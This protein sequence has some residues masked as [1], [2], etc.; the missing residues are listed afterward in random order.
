MELSTSS[1]SLLDASLPIYQAA[2][3]GLDSGLIPDA[4][5]QGQY[6]I[7]N[8]VEGD[9]LY[10]LSGHYYEDPTYWV[11]IREADCTTF[12]GDEAR[13]I[14]VGTPVYLPVP[15]SSPGSDSLAPTGV[16]TAPSFSIDQFPLTGQWLPYVIQYG[17]RL[18]NIAMDLLGDP[19][20]WTEIRKDDGTVFAPGEER[21]LKPGMTVLIP[22]SSDPLGNKLTVTVVDN[23]LSPENS[24][25]SIE[26]IDL[27][28]E[29]LIN[30]QTDVPIFGIS[31]VFEGTRFFWDTGIA[32]ITDDSLNI[33]VTFDSDPNAPLILDT[34]EILRDAFIE[35]LTQPSRF[36]SILP[37]PNIGVVRPN[38]GLL[39]IP[40]D[41]R[42]A[43]GLNLPGAVYELELNAGFQ[44]QGDILGIP[45][46]VSWEYSGTA[47]VIQST[48]LAPEPIL[49]RVPETI[50]E[51]VNSVV[52]QIQ[53][54]F[55]G[56]ADETTPPVRDYPRETVQESPLIAPPQPLPETNRENSI[57]EN[58]QFGSNSNFDFQVDEELVVVGAAA[59]L[60]VAAAAVLLTTGGTGAP[61]AAGLAA[62]AIGLWN[63]PSASA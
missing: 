1:Q 14:P 25:P 50:R 31:E 8:V 9:T 39:D 10:D 23:P 40:L 54:G 43:V 48:R 58:T 27:L 41:I 20:R 21:R 49:E 4:L 26:S 28:P 19:F 12:T 53:N 56:V 52:E 63:Q 16:N 6:V 55:P 35:P 59:V 61:V 33:S 38:T 47:Q 3:Y 5:P 32:M 34:D 45:A 15:D 36:V 51:T 60:T 37:N 17:D 30:I 29:G 42:P 22:I 7:H 62:I 57:I 46:T 11:N 44:E 18:W 13:R 24:A 2:S